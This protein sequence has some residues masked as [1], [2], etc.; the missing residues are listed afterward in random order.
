MGVVGVADRVRI[1]AVEVVEVVGSVQAPLE[2]VRGDVNAK[3]NNRVRWLRIG[4]R[5]DDHGVTF[6]PKKPL[7]VFEPQIQPSPAR[8]S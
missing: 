4:R 8:T 7:T 3:K 5:H 1:A 6:F 2:K